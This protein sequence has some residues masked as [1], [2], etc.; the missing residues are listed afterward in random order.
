MPKAKDVMNNYIGM[1]N[2]ESYGIDMDVARN[3]LEYVRRHI[4]C[5]WQA[6]DELGLDVWDIGLHDLSKFDMAEFPGYARHFCGGG[7]PDGF[8]AAW[9]HHMHEN[10]HHWQHWLFPDKFTPRGSCV[11]EGAVPMPEVRIR[12]M[13]ADWHGVELAQTGKWSITS[14]L[15]KNMSI[16]RLHPDSATY[17]R[18]V[19]ANIGYADV[20]YTY[21]FAHEVKDDI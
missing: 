15:A 11:V 9:L 19:L 21:K 5:V 12:E 4:N 10:A 2:L 3:Y 14:W 7:D 13:V 1:L 17:L 6:E 20:V 18:R 16:I 8:A